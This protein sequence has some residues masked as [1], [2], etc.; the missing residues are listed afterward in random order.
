MVDLHQLSHFKESNRLEAK[1]AQ[2]G[3]PHSIWETYSAFANTEGGVILLGVEETINHNLIARGV[4][5]SHKLICDFWNI[6]NGG[7]SDP[8]NA[9]IMKMFGL[10]NIGDRAG[11][12]MPDAI[13]AA[14]NII[15]ADVDYTISPEM[16]RTTLTMTFI[17]TRD[18]S[19]KQGINL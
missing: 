12:G 9:T 7:N 1:L 19:T 3:I 6:I 2:G 13:A 8:R 10:I 14:K 4:N 15:H 17:K 16:E 11:T 5:D 18:K